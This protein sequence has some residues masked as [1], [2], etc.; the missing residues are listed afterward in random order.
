M[1][2][3]VSA[4][5]DASGLRHCS[6]PISARI[7]ELGRQ[8][9]PAASSRCEP[10]RFQ[11]RSGKGFR[12]SF[13]LIHWPG[14]PWAERRAPSS[15]FLFLAEHEQAVSLFWLSLRVDPAEQFEQ[16]HG[17][18]LH[19]FREPGSPQTLQQLKRQSAPET[20]A[21]LGRDHLIPDLLQIRQQRTHL[22]VLARSEE[23]TSELQS[24]AY[25]VCRLLLEKKKIII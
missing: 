23:H 5:P 21:V 2:L 15:Q 9:E 1:E 18:E 4:H 17:A 16:R 13:G 10:A 8:S 20:H 14:G 3:P 24:L 22:V 19:H 12:N 11:Q 7:Q 6:G 25:L